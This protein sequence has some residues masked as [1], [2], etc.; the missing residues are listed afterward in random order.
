AN[1]RRPVIRLLDWHTNQPDS[2]GV[3]G[4]DEA[5]AADAATTVPQ[6]P[7]RVV[8]DGL[9]ITGR[10]VEITGHLSQVLIRH[11]TLVPGWS[12]DNKCN[13]ERER[14]ASMVLTDT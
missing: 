11:C 7:P 10:G 8:F 5:R 6:R 3:F 2:L 1:G 4:P 13:D 12:L 9:L 14:E